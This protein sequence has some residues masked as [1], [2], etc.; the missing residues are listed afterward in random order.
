MSFPENSLS[1]TPILD[2][3]KNSQKL[4]FWMSFPQ[5]SLSHA[6][7]FQNRPF[8]RFWMSFPENT[9]SHTPIFWPHLTLNP[10]IFIGC[11]SKSDVIS[12]LGALPHKLLITH[13]L[14]L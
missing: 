6:P 9:L 7:K 4:W 14:Y 5:I 3:F 10:N 13:D 11:R 12:R 1:H 2:I 8:H